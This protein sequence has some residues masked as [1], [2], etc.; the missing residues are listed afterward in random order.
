MFDIIIKYWHKTPGSS[1]RERLIR[2]VKHHEKT[3]HV[4]IT[5]WQDL[6]ETA[7]GEGFMSTLN[8]VRVEAVVN[9]NV[10]EYNWVAKS[11]PRDLNRL[12]IS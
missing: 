7:K 11:L 6:G 5:S 9:G 2:A 1:A 12:D 4:D 10:K 8:T 3:E